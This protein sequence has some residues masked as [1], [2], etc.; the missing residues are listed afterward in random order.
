VV[1][2]GWWWL[3]LRCSRWAA[4][5]SS[6]PLHVVSHGGGRAPA[7]SAANLFSGIPCWLDSLRCCWAL[8]AAA[9]P[10]VF[11]LLRDRLAVGFECFASP[12]NATFARFGS[13]FPDVD[14][15]FG[16][17]GSFFRC[18]PVDVQRRMRRPGL[19]WVQVCR[20]PQPALPVALQL[21]LVGR[22]AVLCRMPLK[23]G[24]YEVNPPFVPALLTA[25]AQRMLT[26]L[27]VSLA[28]ARAPVA[29][30][31]SC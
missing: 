11:K 12:L 15:P 5:C 4:S 1:G 16:S 9:G 22:G 8:Q 31:C 19:G 26:L 27:Q 20:Y 29:R 6:A 10:P 2:A 17:A 25:T 21:E 23:H 7:C 30:Q 18:G 13:A 28:A 3:L 24:S 14:G